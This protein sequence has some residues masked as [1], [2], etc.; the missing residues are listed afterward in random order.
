MIVRDFAISDNGELKFDIS[1]KDAARAIEDG[2]IRQIALCR[3]K[4]V[5]NDWL[6]LI[7]GQI[8]KSL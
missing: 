8:L 7:L 2:L 3:I 5:V 6:T 4:S 1:Q